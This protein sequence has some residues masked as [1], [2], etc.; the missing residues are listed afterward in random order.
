MYFDNPYSHRS[1]P[2]AG[3]GSV[4]ARRNGILAKACM[5]A[6][7]QRMLFA[8]DPIISEF[9]ASNSNTLLSNATNSYADWVEIHNTDAANS[10]DVAGWY[11]TNKPTSNL[12]KFKIPT[13]NS[14]L[15]TIAPNCYLIIFASNQ[16]G[17]GGFLT[18]GG[19]TEIHANFNLGASADAVA[20]VKPDGISLVSSYTWSASPPAGGIGPQLTDVSYG[21][22]DRTTLL[23]PAAASKTY[24]PLDNSLGSAWTQ[25]GFNDS[26][27]IGGTTGVGYKTDGSFSS[28]I[29]TNTQSLMS[30]KAS[31]AYIRIPFSVANPAAFNTLALSMMYDDGFVAYL[32]GVEIVRRNTPGSVA[33]NSNATKTI[34]SG[35]SLPPTESFDITGNKNLL[36]SGTNVLA[37]QGLND[38]INSPDFLINPTITGTQGIPSTGY[39]PSATPGAPNS[40]GISGYVSDLQLDHSGGF[41]SSPFDL[42]INTDTAGATIYYTTDGSAPSATNG[43]TYTGPIH[44]GQNAR[45]TTIVRAAAFAQ[46]LQPTEITTESYLFLNDVL[47][48]AGS[49]LDPA[50]FPAQ[51]NSSAADYNV[52]QSITTG[53]AYG[54]GF[55]DDLKSVKTVSLVMDPRDLFDPA[56]GIYSNP[57]QDGDAWKRAGSIEVINPDGTRDFQTNAMIT[58]EGGGSRD[59]NNTDKHSF[60]LFFNGD[61]GSPTQLSQQF[62]PDS[63]LD[64]FNTLILH[65]TFNNTWTQVNTAEQQR[66]DYVKDQFGHDS[67]L[68]MGGP[69]SHGTY[70]QLYINGVYW[71]LYNPMERPDAAWAASYYGGNREDWDVMHDQAL[72]DGNT[73][74]WNQ[75]FAIANDNSLTADQRYQNLK[76]YLDFKSLADYMI[77]MSYTANRDWDYHNWYAGAD[78]VGLNNGDATFKFWTWDS[79]RTLEGVNDNVLNVNTDLCPTRLFQQLKGSSDFRQLFADRVQ[80]FMFNGGALTPSASIARYLARANQIRGAVVGESARWGDYRKSPSYTRDVDWQAEVDRLTSGPNSYFAQR[81]SK[82]IAQYRAAGLFAGTTLDAPIFS[83]TG[84]TV[85]PGT[86]LSI[87]KSP[88]TVGTI[89]YTLDGTD[90]RLEGGLLSGTA[91]AYVG[92]ITLNSNV[93]I[94]S[95]AFNAGSWSSVTEG[96]FLMS[97]APQVRITEISYHPK[98][99]SGS[100][101]VDDDLEFIELENL[102]PGAVDLKNY[103]ISGGVNFTFPTTIL[104]AGEHVVVVSNLTAFQSI[105][106]TSVKVA[107]AFSGHLANSTAELKLNG[108][109]GESILNFFYTDGWYPTT[110]GDGNT[111]VINNPND[112]PNNWGNGA[113][114]HASYNSNGTPGA[115]E[116]PSSQRGVVVSELLSNP[117]SGSTDGDLVELHNTTDASIDVNGW[118]LSDTRSDPKKYRIN[119]VLGT[120]TVIAA[121]GFLVLKETATFG[122]ASDPGAITPFGFAKTGES[123]ILSSATAEGLTEYQDSEDFGASDVDTPFALYTTSDGNTDFVAETAASFGSANTAPVVGPIVINEIMYNPAGTDDEFV[124]LRN[125]TNADV[126]LY[127]PANPT[128]TWRFT[129]GITFSFPTTPASP[130]PDNPAPIIAANGYAL[131]IPATITA[132]AFRAKYGVPANVSIFSGYTGAFDN[133]GEAVELSR[134]AAPE[135]DLSVP[136]IVVDHIHYLPTAPWP[137]SPKGTGPSLSRVISGSYGN[138]PTN[139]AA[140]Q[141]KGTPGTDNFNSNQAPVVS[142]GL[143]QVIT[144]PTNSV[145]LH[146]TAN[147]DGKPNPP[148]TLTTTWNVV[149]NNAASVQFGDTSLVV[150]TAT[151]SAPGVYLLKLTGTDGTLSSSS[152]VQITVNTAPTDNAGVDQYI[153]FA[154][155][156]PTSTTITGTASDSDALPNPP[157]GATTTWTVVSSPSQ[158][159]VA[160]DDAN[161]LSTKATFSASGV[162]VLRLTANDGAATAQDDVQVTVNHLPL[163]NAGSGDFIVTPAL[164]Y[165]LQGVVTDD[166]L[167]TSPGVVPAI[168]TKWTLFDGPAGVSFGDSSIPGTTVTFTAVG[169]YTLRLTATENGVDTY[170]DVVISVVDNPLKPTG[171]P[172][173]ATQNVAFTGNVAKFNYP[174]ATA[175]PAT[176][177]AIIDWGDGS[178]T[179]G[180]ISVDAISGFDVSGTHTYAASGSLPVKVT[181]S[182]GTY[183]GVAN[184]T[185]TIAATAPTV[186]AFNGASINEGD[187]YTSSGSFSD[188]NAGP[189]TATVNYGDGSG[190]QALTLDQ[191]AKTFSLSHLY[192][193]NGSNT[194]TVVLTNTATS[195][196]NSN[197]ASV[198]T[199]NVKPTITIIAGAQIQAF[200]TFSTTGSFT[201]PGVLDTFTATVNYGD[202]SSVQALTLNGENFS[203]S[204]IYAAGGSFTITVAVSD[205]ASATGTNTTPVSVQGP[206]QPTGLISQYQ[207]DGNADDSIGGNNGTPAITPTYVAGHSGQALSFNGTTQLVTIAN[208]AAL[209]P[210]TAI[211]LSAWVNASNW[212]GNHRILQKGNGDNQYRLLAEKGVLKFDLKGVGTVTAAPPSSSTTNAASAWHLITGAYDGATMVLYIDGVAVTSAAHTGPI[213]VTA[214]PLVIG[215]KNLGTTGSDHWK[216]LLDDVRVYNRGLSEAEVQAL[217]SGGT[218]TPQ[219]TSIQIT[220]T[221]AGL[222]NG[223]TKTFTATALDQNGVAMTTQPTFV[224][225]LLSNSVGSINAST[226]VYTAPA[227]GTGSATVQA[228]V[229][230]SGI[231]SNTAAVTVTATQQLT[232]I[233]ITPTSPQLNNGATQAFS[234]TALDQNGVA[235]TTQ[236]TFTWSLLNAA[237]G[238]INTTTGVYTA[239]ASGTGSAQVQATTGNVTS[240]TATV[241]VTAVQADAGLIARYLFDGSA[242]DSAGSNNGTLVNSPTFVTGHVGQALSLNGSTQAVTVANAAALNPTSAITLSSWINATD[243]KGNRRILQK[244]NIDSQYRLLAENG[245]LKF[246]LKGVGTITAALPTTGA[247]HL[248]TGTYDGAAMVLYVDGVAVASAAKSGVIATTADPLAIGMKAGSTVAGNFFKGL[249]DDTRIYSRALSAAEVQ[250]LFSGV[251][252]PQQLTSIAI[253]PTTASVVNGTTKSF[254]ATALDQFDKAMA[255]QPTF[256]WSLGSGSIG[257]ID[258]ATGMYT[259]PASGTGSATVQATVTGSGIASNSAAVTVIAPSQ[260][261]G[262]VAQYTFDGTAT[263]STGTNSGTLVSSPT[264]VAGHTGQALSLNGTTQYVTVADSASLNPTTAI[265]LS[266]WVNATS[267]NGNRRIL[268]KGNKDNQYRLLAENGVLKFDLKGVGTITAALPSVSATHAAS[269]WHLVTATY[270]GATMNLYVDGVVVASGA[271]TGVIATTTDPLTIGTKNAGTTT[272]N[273]FNGYIDDVRIYN[274]ALSATEIGTLYAG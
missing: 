31:D 269:A 47:T 252:V 253:A 16:S 65:S 185:A 151:F 120:N 4:A 198:V 124:E 147:D 153:T 204:H 155:L 107:G 13:T 209:N 29:G 7:E 85:S 177:T 69:A 254:I 130:T 159:T 74:R 119:S 243:W 114:W 118:Y 59:P 156:G 141:N 22:I 102:G 53:A 274:R 58:M 117:S 135:P 115:D 170:S 240:N 60:R 206:T 98:A 15:T 251:V 178:I 200:G 152:T 250:T 11:L 125:T 190:V 189:W 83:N 86:T 221:S 20:L 203:L 24:V 140:G 205:N 143:A 191:N 201:D 217:F 184:T 5:E 265:T 81:T 84:G 174:D 95:R 216:G 242:T 56:T 100:G 271:F 18:G 101:L 234:A 194:V 61:G 99:A 225:S 96:T 154:P 248:V 52:D 103:T 273:Y 257:T 175:T 48:Q 3:K 232:S 171:V 51:W 25:S 80:K 233:Q 270:D 75:M 41:Y 93:H 268:Q 55:I 166:G 149:S 39:L 32:N 259:A 46:G 266:A 247:W 72:S 212:N 238:T 27:W 12:K 79:E 244:G 157:G 165:A 197:S 50:Q 186:N 160:F 188:I 42:T 43:S 163:V 230:G 14:A 158:A 139:W 220:P 92:T 62:F 218:V 207:F 82:A 104:N 148:A 262:L 35:I 150:T 172:V 87:T 64:S 9:M 167:Q 136:Y 105:Y 187:T 249:L 30:S 110:D 45:G 137:T 263:D 179:A 23:G 19:T 28:A 26:S 202:G 256:V 76:P 162:Y 34:S 182:D 116:L 17:T 49:G 1:A 260:N 108:S 236:P 106:G 231:V 241:T 161:A 89:Y 215:M 68:A 73:D 255:T 142:A 66:A 180:V 128:N 222:S 229:T 54:P 237:L 226:G 21:T 169:D 67:A 219:L 146:G 37:I 70:M 272:S 192:K 78:R 261:P 239:P 246:D 133:A 8:T 134:P 88:T 183:S 223:Q 122:N 235:M 144:G 90:P 123:V 214:D 127:D 94:L 10:L 97:N 57:L 228:T 224:W 227:S 132:A 267:W 109:L 33:W 164:Q 176:F 196:S 245:V 63:P 126:L 193:D 181:V 6:L 112:N 111:L 77:L 129:N 113:S 145:T 2:R 121:G 44:I 210:T 213:A 168:T 36:V 40:S 211:T 173:G 131:V 264:Y 38:K 195:Q 91:I 71:G 208:A 258:S 138:E 199:A